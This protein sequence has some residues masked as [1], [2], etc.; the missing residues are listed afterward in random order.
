V[1]NLNGVTAVADEHRGD[2]RADPEI[3]VTV[4]PDASTA[5]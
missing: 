4:V 3:S 2:D 1:V 5:E